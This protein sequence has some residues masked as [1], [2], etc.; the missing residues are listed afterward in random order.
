MPSFLRQGEVECRA[1]ADGRFNPNPSAVALDNALADSQAD[2]AAG[3]CV[4]AMQ[5]LEDEKHALEILR[6]NT[7]AIVTDAEE[8]GEGMGND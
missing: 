6:R 2:A 5:T 8:P 4:A 3:I 7:D 1:L